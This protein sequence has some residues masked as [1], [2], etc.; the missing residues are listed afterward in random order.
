MIH[1][2]FGGLA[3]SVSLVLGPC[4][5]PDCAEPE[6]PKPTSP[7]KAPAPKAKVVAPEKPVRQRETPSRPESDRVWDKVAHCESRNRWDA[8]PSDYVGAYNFYGGLQFSL[9]S[10]EG[11][12]GKQYAPRADLA[13]REVQIAMARRLLALQGPKAWPHC[14][15]ASGLNMV[16][17]RPDVN[18]TP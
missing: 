5:P 11:V 18:A 7:S 9:T 6:A 16:N 13:S 14:G 4:T 1:I 3:L 2:Q 15:P 17:G 8:H 10:W 12:G